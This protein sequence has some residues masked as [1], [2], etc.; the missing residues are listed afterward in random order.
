[1]NIILAQVNPISIDIENNKNKIKGILE[2]IEKKADLV[3]FPKLFLYGYHK[4]DSLKTY[5]FIE[6]QIKNALE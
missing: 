6:N 1:M 2:N 4:F 3:I 5:P